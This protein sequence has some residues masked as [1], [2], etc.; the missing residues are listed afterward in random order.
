MEL[1]LAGEKIGR[2]WQDEMITPHTD[3][4]TRTLQCLQGLAEQVKIVVMYPYG[5]DDGRGLK[6]ILLQHPKNR[7]G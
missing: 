4:T 5:L 3:D 7:I 6:G 2:F 1:K